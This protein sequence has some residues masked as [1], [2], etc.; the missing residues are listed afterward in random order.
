MIRRTPPK[1]LPPRP[2]LKVGD[3]VRWTEDKVV[4][5]ECGRI[6]AIYFDPRAEVWIASVRFRTWKPSWP[7]G[8]FA[9]VDTVN[10]IR[11]EE[12]A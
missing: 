5:A 6:E 3:V 12:A 4:P 9:R 11:S 8:Q 7:A 10:V 2:D 1:Q